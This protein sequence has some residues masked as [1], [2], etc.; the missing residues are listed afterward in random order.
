[1]KYWKNIK[2][3]NRS[4][5]HVARLDAEVQTELATISLHGGQEAA[6]LSQV[7]LAVREV[8]IIPNPNREYR[9][10]DPNEYVI[11]PNHGD[12]LDEEFAYKCRKNICDNEGSFLY[13]L[14]V[15]KLPAEVIDIR[16]H[17]NSELARIF[18]R[19]L[20]GVVFYF[21]FERTTKKLF[22][23]LGPYYYE[24]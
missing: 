12:W 1:M 20:N 7:K 4:A 11:G 19:I 14:G 22:K 13:E 24:S 18:A 23:G 6:E 15:D 5:E 9:R 3:K 21:G 16:G 17:I 2:N 8:N 10:D